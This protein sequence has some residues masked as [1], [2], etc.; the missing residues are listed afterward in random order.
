M[1]TGFYHKHKHNVDTQLWFKKL[2]KENNK[3]TNAEQK[4]NH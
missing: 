1:A 4:K 2:V 3:T